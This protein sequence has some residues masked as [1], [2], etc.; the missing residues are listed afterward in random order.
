M[1]TWNVL[2][3]FPFNCF[4][5]NFTFVH[6]KKTKE[7]TTFLLKIYQIINKS[8]HIFNE[9]FLCSHCF[10]ITGWTYFFICAFMFQVFINHLFIKTVPPL[11]ASFMLMLLSFFNVFKVFQSSILKLVYP[12]RQLFKFWWFIKWMVT[13]KFMEG[14]CGCKKHKVIKSQQLKMILR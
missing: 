12:L 6:C 3:T 2:G 14:K 9:C 7:I 1:E 4:G 13:S 11:S 5:D 8:F 10:I